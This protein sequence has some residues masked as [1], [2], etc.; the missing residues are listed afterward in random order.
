MPTMM[1]VSPFLFQLPNHKHHQSH[2]QRPSKLIFVAE[3]EI[4]KQKNLTL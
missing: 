3:Q 4:G 2:V 1:F